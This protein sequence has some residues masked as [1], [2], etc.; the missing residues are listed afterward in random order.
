M[1]IIEGLTQEMLQDKPDIFLDKTTR[2]IL[3]WNPK[4][5]GMEQTYQSKVNWKWLF[6]VKKGEKEE[7]E[8]YLGDMLEEYMEGAAKIIDTGNG[9]KKKQAR[10]L[11]SYTDVLMGFAKPQEEN[12]KQMNIDGVPVDI[13]KSPFPNRKRQSITIKTVEGTVQTEQV[14]EVTEAGKTLDTTKF[15]DSIQELKRELEDTKKNNDQTQIG[16]Q[17]RHIVPS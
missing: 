7:V 6:I 2:D 14:W 13:T 1:I 11:G 4:I 16:D 12:K 3:L 15:M 5:E 9:Q 8:E 10:A 17:E